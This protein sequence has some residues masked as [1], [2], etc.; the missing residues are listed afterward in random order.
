MVWSG[1]NHL[2]TG[3][4]NKQIISCAHTEIIGMKILCLKMSRG[5]P[6]HILNKANVQ[7]CWAPWIF[8]VNREKKKKIYICMCLYKKYKWDNRS[9]A[10]II[11]CLV[12]RTLILNPAA[13]THILLSRPDS[14]PTR[15]SHNTWI[16][17][18]LG[19]RQWGKVNFVP[20]HLRVSL[21]GSLQPCGFMCLCTKVGTVDLAGPSLLYGGRG[22]QVQAAVVQRA[23][24]S[25]LVGADLW[26]LRKRA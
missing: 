23:S 14:L 19:P 15:Y 26:P 11:I 3:H 25:H 5:K 12:L 9:C 2:T 7:T 13:K 22:W 17:V 4:N 20:V 18:I 16:I 6:L 1:M 24:E 8:F 21:S 10:W